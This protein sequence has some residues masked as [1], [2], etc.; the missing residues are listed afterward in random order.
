[1]ALASFDATSASGAI[2]FINKNDFIP[3]LIPAEQVS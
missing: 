3:V 2:I 1:M